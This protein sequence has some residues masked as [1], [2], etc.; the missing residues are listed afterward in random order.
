MPI[1]KYMK[2]MR[3]D[4]VVSPDGAAITYERSGDG[5]SLV[6]LHG[7]GRDR[8]HWRL[9]LP[10]L[11]RHATVH[12]VD[13]RG[14]GQSDDAEDYAIER[15]VDD[16]LA[17]LDAIDGPVYLLGHSFGAIV[18]LEAALRV[19]TLSGLILYE[20][21]FNVFLDMVSTELGD[22][23]EALMLTGDREAVLTTFL[24][25]GPHYPPEV[26][27]AQREQP[28]WPERLRFAHTLPREVQAV[29]RYVFTPERFAGLRTPCLLLLGSES[30]PFFRQAIEAL[31][32]V[33][34]GSNMVELPGQHHNAMESAPSLFADTVH[35]FVGG[36]P[37]GGE[38]QRH[39][40][41]M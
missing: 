9:S 1:P 10:E 24:R 13:R 16:A 41:A 27:A 6:L 34:P 5:P 31:D 4:T 37:G 18:A 39:A 20:P 19:N 32:G 26:I 23:L 30:P 3:M 14:R 8:A 29:N 12:A 21:P 28:D 11:A 40:H 7:A 22:K 33:L 36:N 35:R 15:E 2:G 25:E 17:V 38:Q